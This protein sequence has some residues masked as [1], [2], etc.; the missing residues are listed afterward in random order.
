MPPVILTSPL[1]SKVCVAASVPM[2][3]SPASKEISYA[4]VPTPTFQGLTATTVVAIPTL[5]N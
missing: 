3:T 1:T 2:P 5:P 4:N